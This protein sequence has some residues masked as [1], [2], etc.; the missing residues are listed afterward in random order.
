MGWGEEWKETVGR[1]GRDEREKGET[2][3]ERLKS[4]F[5]HYKHSLISHEGLYSVIISCYGNRIFSFFWQQGFCQSQLLHCNE[6]LHSLLRHR[7]HVHMSPLTLHVSTCAQISPCLPVTVSCRYKNL[8][9]PLDGRHGNG[10]PMVQVAL[11]SGPT[12]YSEAFEVFK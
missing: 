12:Q 11:W 10:N 9:T 2:T 1:V 5:C 8:A 3:E 7:N 6:P 4:V